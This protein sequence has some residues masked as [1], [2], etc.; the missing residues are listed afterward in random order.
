MSAK[1][2]AVAD[3]ARVLPARDNTRVSLLRIAWIVTVL[4]CL[5]TAV[6]LVLSGYKGYAGV[7]VAVGLAA[8]INVR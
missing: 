6:L 5:V 7:F 1:L 8:A 4:I 2:P 3:V